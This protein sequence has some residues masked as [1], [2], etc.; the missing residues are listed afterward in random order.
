MATSPKIMQLVGSLIR[1]MLTL[2]FFYI[3]KMFLSVQNNV[4]LVFAALLCSFLVYR[5][6][7]LIVKKWVV[8]ESS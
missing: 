7:L 2:A 8:K 3:F 6:S 4:V 1:I 5:G